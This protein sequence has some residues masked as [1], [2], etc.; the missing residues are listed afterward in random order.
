MDSPKINVRGLY[1]IF[2]PNPTS[3]MAIVREGLSRE[4]IMEEHG[5]L[6]ALRDIN[7]SVP[8][9]SIQVLMGQ[10]G[11]GKS[12][13]IRHINRLIKPTEGDVYI[14]DDNVCELDDAELR[15]VRRN[16]VSMVFQ[17]FA[18]LPHRTTLENVAYGLTVQG[19][20][21]AIRT[22]LAQKWVK[23]VG[24]TGFEK[25]H[26]EGLSGGMRQR[27]GIARALATD[28]DILLMDEPFNALDPLIRSDMQSL[29]LDLQRDLQKTIIF[30]THDLDEAIKLG[31][32]IAILRH[33]EILQNGDSQE[34]ILDPADAYISA[35]TKEIN[36][37][38]VIR[39]SSIMDPVNLSI[40]A[41]D[42]PA[43]LLIEDALPLVARAPDDHAHVIDKT[44]KKIG[45]VTTNMLIGALSS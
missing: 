14:D 25:I 8:S 7:F 6:V 10:S 23:R 33:G 19:V 20:P 29:L 28:A 3:V 27:V 18:L 45:I 41:P 24:L 5:H 34:I 35:F 16:K 32:K 39:V 40:N 44:G 2:G 22:E 26:P 1:K 43:S 12:T 31:D 42:C 9:Q 17:H 37:A 15:E 30:V 21:T 13:L 36:R 11:S 4:K 38:R